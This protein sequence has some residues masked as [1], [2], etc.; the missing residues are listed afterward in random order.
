MDKIIKL[1][2]SLGSIAPMAGPLATKPYKMP[3][4]ERPLDS[5]TIDDYLKDDF[6][7]VYG[8][9]DNNEYDGLTNEQFAYMMENNYALTKEE[10]ID[11]MKKIDPYYDSY[12]TEDSED[13]WDDEYDDLADIKDE[14]ISD[15]E[16]NFAEKMRK[17][18]G[19]KV[20]TVER[21]YRTVK[22]LSG[23]KKPH[24]FNN[25]F[26]RFWGK[27]TR[28]VLWLFVGMSTA[29]AVTTGIGAL[30]VGMIT[31]PVAMKISDA[32]ERGIAEKHIL[33]YKDQIQLLDEAISESAGKDKA[34]L[35]KAKRKLM[36]AS[37]DIRKHVDSYDKEHG[38]SSEY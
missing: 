32:Q 15:K 35:M 37:T 16:S 33:W 22:K 28:M 27:A 29:A 38:N 3:N 14:P 13:Y 7:K 10:M 8:E 17:S 2:A 5:A 30:F 36:S 19:D 34:K 20:S 21:A 12:L 18:N 24:T 6:I 25:S 11:E 1:E 26:F 31:V 4:A 23:F 9:E